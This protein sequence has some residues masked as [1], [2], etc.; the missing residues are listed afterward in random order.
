LCHNAK[1]KV[2][3]SVSG[4]ES[5]AYVDMTLDMLSEFGYRVQQ[6]QDGKY[7]IDPQNF[8]K[9][10]KV[11]VE[12]EKDWSSAAYTL[13]AG[14]IAG[15]MVVNG[16]RLDSLQADAAILQ[17]LAS[18][19]VRLTQV[20]DMIAVE[21]RNLMP[22]EFDASGCPDLFP[23]LAI[24]A[25][26]C[27]GES[28]IYGVHRLFHKESNRVASIAEMLLSFGIPFSVDDDAFSITGIDTFRSCTV[29]TFNDHRIAMAAAL[30][31]LRADGSVTLNHTKCVKKSYPGFFRDMILS[32]M[33]C[34]FFDNE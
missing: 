2:T 3:I 5:V 29:D 28:N 31:A 24:L 1:S 21:H 19:G 20:R 22:F 33:V 30:G 27:N 26:C 14:A 23:V 9:K 7:H 4:L 13:V 6:V 16:L 12:I 11:T 32:G 34:Q 17:V 18:V 25:G 8:S 10:S 15:N